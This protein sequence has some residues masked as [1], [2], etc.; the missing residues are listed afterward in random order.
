MKL[1]G[2]R[3]T[4]LFINGQQRKSF[5]SIH[6]ASKSTCGILV[7]HTS[8]SVYVITVSDIQLEIKINVVTRHL[9]TIFEIPNDVCCSI[10]IDSGLCG[11]CDSCK[12]VPIRSVCNFGTFAFTSA[13]GYISSN[14]DQKTIEKEILM[15]RLKK[16]ESILETTNIDNTY[17]SDIGSD[18]AVCFN[19]SSIIANLG[20][21][22]DGSHVT[23]EFFIK[24]CAQMSCYGTVFSYA[25]RQSLTLFYERT[26]IVTSGNQQWN[27]SLFL[28]D[29]EWNQV[30]LV[31]NKISS[32]LDVYVFNHVG[33]TQRFTVNLP[34]FPFHSGGNL[35]LGRAQ[36]VSNEVLYKPTFKFIGCIDE[37]R[38]WKKYV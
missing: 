11:R 25:W 32:A 8:A 14:D 29:N 10:N 24:T 2:K 22:I 28:E 15:D 17:I 23:I 13:I 38:I 4:E 31:Y 30:A 9:T 36:P 34:N 37:F 18:S 35:V 27:T 20:D 12:D 6:L 19:D 21:L 3:N 7:T 5:E 16:G 26:L 33:T 1:K